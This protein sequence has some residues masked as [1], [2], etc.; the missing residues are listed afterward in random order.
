MIPLAP[1]SEES[2]KGQLNTSSI[3]TR[4]M[5]SS[6]TQSQDQEIMMRRGKFSEN[7][8]DD[9]KD[10]LSFNIQLQFQYTNNLG[11]DIYRDP[12]HHYAFKIGL[13]EIY[14]EV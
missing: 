10:G 14:K 2:C 3:A 11:T 1:I 9:P 12:L 4:D 7:P 8:F 6:E 5:E 13:V